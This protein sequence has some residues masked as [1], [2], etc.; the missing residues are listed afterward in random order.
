MDNLFV[1]QTQCVLQTGLERSQFW[2]LFDFKSLRLQ[3]FSVFLVVNEC[4]G[5]KNVAGQNHKLIHFN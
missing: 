1:L 5:S 4:V 2:S 3:R